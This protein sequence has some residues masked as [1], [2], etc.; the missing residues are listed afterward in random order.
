MTSHGRIS[1]YFVWPGFDLRP[2][3]GSDGRIDYGFLPPG[4]FQL[5]TEKFT[6][7]EGEGKVGSSPR[8]EA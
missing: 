8:D 5:L 2:I 7:L 1:G 6:A 4:F 3:K